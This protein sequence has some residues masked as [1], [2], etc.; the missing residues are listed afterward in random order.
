MGCGASST[1]MLRAQLQQTTDQMQETLKQSQDW[2]ARLGNRPQRIFLLRHAESIAVVDPSLQEDAPD[3]ELPLSPAGVAQAREAGRLLMQEM[4]GEP[5]QLWV[6]P[7]RRALETAQ[8]MLEGTGIPEDMWPEVRVDVRLRDQNTGAF[9]QRKQ[10]N[11]S[12]TAMTI[13]D[14]KKRRWKFGAFY[15]RFQNGEDGAEVYSRVEG[16]VGSMVRFY[17]KR[18]PQESGQNAVVISHG[19]IHRIFLMRWLRL[20]VPWLHT[21]RNLMHA[22]WATLQRGALSCSGSRRGWTVDREL[23]EHVFYD[24]DLR[25]PASALAATVFGN[26][27][28]GGMAHSPNS[29]ARVKV[30]GWLS[31]KIQH[32]G[33]PARLTVKNRVAKNKP[34]MYAILDDEW[35]KD[36]ASLDPNPPLDGEWEERV[37]RATAAAHKAAE[38]AKALAVRHTAHM[39]FS[40]ARIAQCT[41]SYQYQPGNAQVQ[42]RDNGALSFEVNTGSEV[43]MRLDAMLVSRL[44]K[45]VGKTRERVERV[46]ES[47]FVQVNG[48]VERDPGRRV[49]RN[50]CVLW[51]EQGEDGGEAEE[52]TSLVTE[53]ELRLVS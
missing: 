5:F 41:E 40:C 4:K 6:S 37:K 27:L 19:V 47:G 26:E 33:S 36:L 15:Y 23:C 51:E 34:D 14:Q 30:E 43:G 2:T 39:Q 32:K 18:T 52:F 3:E 29:T 46:V 45:S 25:T 1:A 21:A 31:D 44:P 8:A 35:A 17:Q 22:E 50:D 20:G 12:G 13:Q 53:E 7:F 9:E 11:A 48:A 28:P 10:A 38:K 49:E 16:F 24:G 42:E